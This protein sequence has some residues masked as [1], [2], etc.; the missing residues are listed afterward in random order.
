M[1]ELLKTR[2]YIVRFDLNG[3]NKQGYAEYRLIHF[4]LFI[5]FIYKL[6][7]FSILLQNLYLKF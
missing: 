1:Y 2:D 4:K 7:W 3:K 5:I 6:F